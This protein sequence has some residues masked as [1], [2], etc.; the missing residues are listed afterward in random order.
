[1]IE[2]FVIWKAPAGVQ[3]RI[4]QLVEQSHQASQEAKRLLTEAKAEVERMIEGK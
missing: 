2:N 1:V 3:Q 4:R